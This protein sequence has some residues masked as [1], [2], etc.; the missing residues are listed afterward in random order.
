MTPRY[1]VRDNDDKFGRRFAA[2]AEGTRIELVMIPQRSPNLNPICERFLGSVRRECLDHVAIVTVRQLRRLLG[3]YVD[4][5]F[6]RARPHQ[7]LNQSI[8]T[9]DPPPS[10]PELDGNILAHPVLGGLHHDYRWAA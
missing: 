3:E 8:P 10:V 7:G 9:R 2:V 5:Y 1:L 6:N 4:S